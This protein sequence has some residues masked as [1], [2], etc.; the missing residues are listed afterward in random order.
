[1]RAAVM[2]DK[3][4]VADSGAGSGARLPARCW[5]ARWPAASAA[6]TSTSSSTPTE[7]AE[8]A[9]ESGAEGFDHGPAG[10]TS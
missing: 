6:P 7:M 2:R 3:Q 4:I 1:M 5:C 9:K 10:A 8:L